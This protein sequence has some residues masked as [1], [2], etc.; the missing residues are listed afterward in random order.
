VLTREV[1]CNLAIGDVGF[2][3][4]DRTGNR[5]VASDVHGHAACAEDGAALDAAVL[6]SG[7]NAS[8]AHRHAFQVGVR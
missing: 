4:R 3:A 1:R 6:V 5:P 2:E 7:Y 8:P